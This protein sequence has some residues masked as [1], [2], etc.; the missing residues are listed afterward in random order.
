MLK[1]LKRPLLLLL[2]GFLV[3]IIG[4]WAKILHLSFADVLLTAGMVLEAGGVIYAIYVLLK[5][6]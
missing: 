6:K 3:T 2:L 5:S 1:L 4:A